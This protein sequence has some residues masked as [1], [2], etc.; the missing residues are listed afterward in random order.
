VQVV[1]L[2]IEDLQDDNALAAWLREEVMR[3]LH[4]G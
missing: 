4:R 2:A 3:H 1:R